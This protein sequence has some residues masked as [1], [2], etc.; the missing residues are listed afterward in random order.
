MEQKDLPKH[1]EHYIQI[2]A[3]ELYNFTGLIMTHIRSK[4]VAIL[5]KRGYRFGNK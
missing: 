4:H 2:S 5:Y 1:A 3:Q